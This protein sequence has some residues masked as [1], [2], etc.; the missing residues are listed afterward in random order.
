MD[1]WE[2]PF[3]ALLGR[4]S[5]D[6]VIHD[7]TQYWASGVAAKLRIP[8]IFFVNTSASSSGFLLGHEAAIV[9]KST[10]VP[11]LTLPP[12]GFPSAHIRHSW[13]GARKNLHVFRKNAGQINM[14]EWWSMCFK[15]SW[16]IAFNRCVELEGK[17]LEYLQRTTSMSVVVVVAIS[18]H[19][20]CGFGGL[21]SPLLVACLFSVLATCHGVYGTL[22]SLC[23]VGSLVSCK[24]LSLLFGG[25]CLVVLD[26]LLEF[27]SGKSFVFNKGLPLLFGGDCSYLS[28]AISVRFHGHYGVWN[29][30]LDGWGP[31]SCSSDSSFL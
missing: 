12:P 27:C 25:V 2:K 26:A 17:Y 23:Y 24:I 16:V 21:A 31:S 4:V 30:V 10:I 29:H 20:V 8:T 1:E 14:A 6:F 18:Y 7:M 11:N 3:E 15:G 22:L 19:V 5:P 28:F 9:E 13:F